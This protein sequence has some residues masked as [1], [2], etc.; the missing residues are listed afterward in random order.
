[1]LL[2]LVIIFACISPYFLTYQNIS[3]ILLASSI[4][5]IISLGM[6]FVIATSGIDLSVGSILAF[7]SCFA[8]TLALDN[9]LLIIILSIVSAIFIGLINGY[10]IGYKRYPAFIVTLATMS[11]VRGL[12]YIV[13]DALPIY[14]LPDA[15]KFIGQGRLF[16]IPVPI[17]IFIITFVLCYFIKN[18]TKTG[19]YFAFI[20]DNE[21]AS[22][23]AGV[24]T[25]KYKCLAYIISA[26]LCG[27]AGLITIG[28]MN[29][30]DPS[31]GFM[32]E[33][34]AITAV[35]L[36]GTSLFGGKYT[37]TGTL[38]GVLVIGILQNGL[39]LLSV[40]SYYQQVII[41]IILILAIISN[42]QKSKENEN[43]RN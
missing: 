4:I 7:S 20:G 1:M 25:S 33:M 17:I 24:K 10:I 23:N 18:K 3:N 16:M 5:G 34:S 30:A 12:G 32:Y 38:A 11:I 43:I 37:I 27:I 22:F 9:P 31:V 28:R 41:G 15:I 35:I 13:T 6:S 40:T 42:K 2:I 29:T 19:H 14:G 26:F 21:Q 8:V 36:G 39:N